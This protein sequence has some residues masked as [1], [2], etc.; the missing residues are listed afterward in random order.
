[1]ITIL[2]TVQEQCHPAFHWLRTFLNKYVF[3]LFLKEVRH[4]VC[5]RLWGK[6]FQVVWPNTEKAL[7][8]TVLREERGITRRRLPSSDRSDFW[9]GAWGSQLCEVCGHC[10]V[11]QELVWQRFAT[12]CTILALTGSQWSDIRSASF[13]LTRKRWENSFEVKLDESNNEQSFAV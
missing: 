2:P 3:R 1:M 5:L 10:A 11:M 9:G 7:I 12:L 4:S 6:E 13:H 8:P